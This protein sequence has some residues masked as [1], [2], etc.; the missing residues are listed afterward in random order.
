M[1][2]ERI[3]SL[4]LH[5]KNTTIVCFV[6]GNAWKRQFYYNIKI[7]RVQ[8]VNVFACVCVSVWQTKLKWVLSI[9]NKQNQSAEWTVKR[10]L[11]LTSK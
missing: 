11:F 7:Y 8:F 10:L 9:E 5:K 2:P 4:R 3:F 1:R 6:R